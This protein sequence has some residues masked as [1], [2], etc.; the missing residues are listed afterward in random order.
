MWHSK[1]Y[2]FSYILPV[3]F[4]ENQLLHYFT[5]YIPVAEDDYK[6]LMFDD[7]L[8]TVSDTGKELGEFTISVEPTRYK[9]TDCFLIHANSHGSIDGVPCGTSITAYVAQNLETIEQQH[10]EYV[11]VGTCIVIRVSKWTM[12]QIISQWITPKY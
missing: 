11:K 1:C 6:Y 12:S 8:V 4:I 5:C 7:H 9:Q 10:H 3:H 2:L